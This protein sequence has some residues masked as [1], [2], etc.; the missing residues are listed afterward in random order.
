[1]DTPPIQVAPRVGFSWDVNGDGKTAVRGG[2]GVFPDRFNDDI[3]LQHVELPPL[4][5]TPTANYTTI[6]ELLVDAAQ[7][8]PGPGPHPRSGL[9]AAVHLQLQHRR[10]ARP[11]LEA[12]RRLLLRR[13]EGPE[14][15]ADAQPQRGAVRHEL[16]AVEH[17]PDHR[18]R[19]A[20]R[21]PAAVSRLRRHPV[22]GVRRLL[23]L[24]RAADAGE[25]PLHGRAALRRRLHVRQDPERGHRVAA[26]QQ[27]DG[28]PV[29]RRRG[30]QLRRRR[31]AAQ[32]RRR[33]LVPG[34][35]PEREVGLGHRQDLLRRLGDLGRDDG[36]ERR[37]PA[38]RPTRSR[39]SAISPAARARASTAASTSSAIRTCRA[40]IAPRCGPSPPSASR[41]RRWPRTASARRAATRSSAPA[42]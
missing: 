32:P 9:Q 2:F 38:D 23:E 7:P 30:S 37:G 28:E 25:P 12:G 8:E 40:A 13:L 18:R 42:T 26:Q 31:P 39:A 4:V 41:R 35:E 5:N 34:A 20:E 6:S 24:R 15:A 1:M 10:A 11:R 33:L 3:V 16:P 14:A 27:P 21:V 29:P 17:R 19:A 36:A 22:L